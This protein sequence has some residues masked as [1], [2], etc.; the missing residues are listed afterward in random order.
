[1]KKYVRILSLEDED[2]FKLEGYEKEIIGRVFL[3]DEKCKQDGLGCYGE[4]PE[5]EENDH[6]FYF[7][8]GPNLKYVTCFVTR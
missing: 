7:L 1:M 6:W 5:N 3:V 4:Y 2:A 8:S